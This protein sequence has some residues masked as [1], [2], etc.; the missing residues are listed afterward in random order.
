[1]RSF[2]GKK[3]HKCKNTCL[4]CVQRLQLYSYRPEQVLVAD[5][6]PHNISRLLRLPFLCSFGQPAGDGLM[7][8]QVGSHDGCHGPQV[9]PVLFLPGNHLTEELEQGLKDE[10]MEIREA[11]D[12]TA[13]PEQMWSS[14][15]KHVQTPTITWKMF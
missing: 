5:E 8:E 12:L 11:E 9:H 4:V 1:M 3:Q 10:Q 6:Q 2:H 7:E 14:N 13:V 15:T